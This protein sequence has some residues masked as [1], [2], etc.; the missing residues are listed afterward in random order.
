MKI[1]YTKQRCEYTLRTSVKIIYYT[2]RTS[3]KIIYEDRR[4]DNIHRGQ[5]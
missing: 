5:V 2:L 1:I 3:V 4:E